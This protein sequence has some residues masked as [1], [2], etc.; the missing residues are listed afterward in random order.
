MMCPV[1]A[2]FGSRGRGRRQRGVTLIEA[3]VTF[4]ILSV[5]L[6]GAVS[7]QLLSKSSQHQSIQRSRAVLLANDF[8]ERIRINPRGIETYAERDL[9]SPLGAGSIEDPPTTDCSAVA[10]TPEQLADFDLWQ[11]ERA[12][13]GAAVTFEEDGSTI[14]SGGLIEPRACV[15]FV[16]DAGKTRT[17]MVRI[18]L[19]WRGL[20]ESQDAVPA[21]GEACGGEDAGDDDYRRQLVVSTFVIDEAEL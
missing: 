1:D 2:R 9:D 19:Q 14:N 8:V 15:V 11:I 16:A 21:G 4:L 5:G 13:D 7:L 20:T 3:L 18:L 10:C 12:L 6:L 17:G